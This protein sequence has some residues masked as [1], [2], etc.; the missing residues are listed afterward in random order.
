MATRGR[1]GAAAVALGLVLAVNGVA[2]GGSEGEEKEAGQRSIPRSLSRAESA[3]E[4][5]IDLILAGKRDKAVKSAAALDDLAQRDLARDLEG[6]ASKEELGELQARAG[7]LA[8]I[9]PTGEP[10]EVALAANHAFELVAR[11]FGK[12]Q[13]AV[14]ATVLV[15][16]YLDFEAKLRAL[17]H[18]IDQVRVVVTRLSTTWSELLKTYPSGDK[19]AA[20]RGRFD[21]HVAAM[22]SLATAGTDFDGMA[23]EAQHGLDLVDELEEVYAG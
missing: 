22:T 3:A 8:K 20:A 6:I 5:S 12:F 4:D 18:E 16:D 13:S 19:A 17:A 1:R 9:A 15:L 10:I 7:E 11:L 21:A 23:K 2:C 14:P